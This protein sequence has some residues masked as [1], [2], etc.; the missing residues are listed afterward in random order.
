LFTLRLRTA[1][2][3]N[4]FSAVRFSWRHSLWLGL[5]PLQ[6]LWNGRP[7]SAVGARDSHTARRS[8]RGT[9]LKPNQPHRFVLVI[10]MECSM[11]VACSEGSA[12]LPGTLLA[13]R[14]IRNEGGRIA[15]FRNSLCAVGFTTPCAAHL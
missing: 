3:K 6:R 5:P 7:E 13:K 11:A 15:C 2:R 14:K 10:G 12:G 4:C 1:V 9:V 8:S